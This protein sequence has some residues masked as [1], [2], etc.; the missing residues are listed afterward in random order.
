MNCSSLLNA[1]RRGRKT[2]TDLKSI[3]S[4]LYEA[5]EKIRYECDNDLSGRAKLFIDDVL[6]KARGEEGGL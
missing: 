5:L 3:N 1:I 2:E 6:A 4:D